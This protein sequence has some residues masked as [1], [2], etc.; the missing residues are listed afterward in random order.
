NVTAEATSSDGALHVT[1]TPTGDGRSAT[2]RTSTGLFSGDDYFIAVRDLQEA[3][4]HSSPSGGT[5]EEAAA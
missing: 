3:T 5:L 2:I 1:L 4:P